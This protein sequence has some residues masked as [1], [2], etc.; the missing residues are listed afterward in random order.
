MV[1]CT[2]GAVVVVKGDVQSAKRLLHFFVI[3]VHNGPG[4][5]P[6]F[7]ARKVMAAPCSS[8]PHTQTTSRFRARK[9]RTYRSAGR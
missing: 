6:S 4:V 8:D 9:Y 7:R 5:V 2:G 3:P 1:L